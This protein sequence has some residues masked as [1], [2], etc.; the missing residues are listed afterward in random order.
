[1]KIQSYIITLTL[2]SLSVFFTNCAGEHAGDASLSSQGGGSAAGLAAFQN[3]YYTFTKSRGCTACHGTT[4]SPLFDVGDVNAAYNAAR[5]F[6]DFKNPTGSLLI[7]YAGNSHCA[8]ALCSDPS[9]STSVQALI[10]DWANA[11]NAS[12][13]GGN[14]GGGGGTSTGTVKYVTAATALPKT[15]PTLMSSA[16]PALL[17]IPLSSLNPPVAS[18]SKAILEVEVTLINP[19]WYRFS[20]PKIA[21][22]TAA[23]SVSG[24]HLYVRGPLVTTGLG[25]EDPNQGDTWNSILNVTAAIFALPATLPTTALGATPITTNSVYDPIVTTTLTT[26]PDSVTVGFEN[27]Q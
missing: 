20:K 18:L 19:T 15:I 17:R 6:V 11:E 22:N 26:T 16:T 10:V 12:S 27:I 1:M 13:S 14:N 24:L 25:T 4:Q 7:T 2:A 8:A 3:G 5:I 23:V 21:G 9:V